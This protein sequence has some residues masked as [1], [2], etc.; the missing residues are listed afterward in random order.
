MPPKQIPV[1][2]EDHIYTPLVMKDDG[3]ITMLAAEPAANEPGLSGYLIP[4]YTLSDRGTYFVPGSA[5]R[6]AKAKVTL[7]PHLYQHDTYAVLGVHT[8]AVEDDTG[9]RID[10]AFNMDKPLAQEVL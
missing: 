6:T 5:K 7:A 10:V 9:F 8:G 2:D 4:W 3:A 1:L